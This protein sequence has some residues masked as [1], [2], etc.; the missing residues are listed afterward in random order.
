MLSQLL[1]KIRLA[2]KLLLGFVFLTVALLVLILRDPPKT[3]CDIQMEEVN[4]RLAKGFFVDTRD[5][6]YQKGVLQ[7][8]QFC[9]ETNSPGGCFDLFNRLEYYEKQIRSIPAQC[10]AH[11]STVSVGKGL[12]KAL[13]LFARIGWGE[14]P[15][16]SKFK[17]TAWLE[18]DDLGLF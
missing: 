8:F 16:E 1:L 4:Q 2:P 13:K 5:G 7:A 12:R 10:G 9:L 15:P 11:P 17:K 3:L 14:V 6:I 18:S